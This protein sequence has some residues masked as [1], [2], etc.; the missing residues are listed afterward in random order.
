[1]K[2]RITISVVLICCVAVS[3]VFG[4]SY[5]K[6]SVEEAYLELGTNLHGGRYRVE[7]AFTGPDDT[8][9][10]IALNNYGFRLP[11]R[12][13][14]GT[15]GTRTA[16][17]FIERRDAPYDIS[18]F[19]LTNGRSSDGFDFT[20]SDCPPPDHIFV[21]CWPREQQG[22][23][24]TFTNGEALE[25]EPTDQPMQYHVS[26]FRPGYIYSVYASWGPY[27]SEYP[28]LASDQESDRVYW[29]LDG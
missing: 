29:C 5:G 25:F 2:K 8:K 19:A 20:F 10:S 4:Y 11:M 3:L 22:T 24:G 17:P 12:F 14:D 6:K 16:I 21:Q 7:L 18:S 9:D 26:E 1:M 27:Y 28:C 23:D 15:M 13:S